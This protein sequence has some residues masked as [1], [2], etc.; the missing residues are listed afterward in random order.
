MFAAFC[1]D[2]T[3]V[4]SSLRPAAMKYSAMDSVSSSSIAPLTMMSIPMGR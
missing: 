3:M 4:P 1:R 2:D